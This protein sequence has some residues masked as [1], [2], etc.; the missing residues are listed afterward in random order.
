M[1]D[2]LSQAILSDNPNSGWIQ[3]VDGLWRLLA[4]RWAIDSNESCRTHIHI[5]PPTGWDDEQVKRVACGILYF[6]SA[7]EFLLPPHRRGNQYAKSNRIN[8]PHFADMSAA[9]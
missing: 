5:S 1:L 9:Q 4:N 3:R 8:N 2:S 6:E 7:F